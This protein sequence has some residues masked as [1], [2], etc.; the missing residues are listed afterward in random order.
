MEDIETMIDTLRSSISVR[1]GKKQAVKINTW[2]NYTYTNTLKLM[3]TPLESIPFER[4]QRVVERE[5]EAVAHRQQRG[6][7]AQKEFGE[8]L[9]GE[10]AR[11]SDGGGRGRIGAERLR[12]GREGSE[13]GGMSEWSHTITRYII[14]Y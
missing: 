7:I 13:V 12:R 1:D 8:Q 9:G 11:A 14:R 2:I 6:Q 4:R 5:V 10:R 3:S